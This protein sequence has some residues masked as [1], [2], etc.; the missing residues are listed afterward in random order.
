MIL[1][2]RVEFVV[3]IGLSVGRRIRHEIVPP[4]DDPFGVVFE[5]DDSLPP[6]FAGID[7]RPG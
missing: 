5:F 6:F 4:L 1:H 7:L 3:R 2:G